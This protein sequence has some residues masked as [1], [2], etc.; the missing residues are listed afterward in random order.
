MWLPRVV[1]FDQCAPR[2]ESLI[3]P[4]H[5]MR[6]LQCSSTAHSSIFSFYYDEMDMHQTKTSILYINTYRFRPYLVCGLTRVPVS[7]RPTRQQIRLIDNLDSGRVDY[8]PDIPRLSTN[9]KAGVGGV[10]AESGRFIRYCDPYDNDMI[11]AQHKHHESTNC[12]LVFQA[13]HNNISAL[14][15][16][17]MFCRCGI[18]S[19]LHS[20]NTN[21]H[22]TIAQT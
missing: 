9:E 8:I 4:N 15:F 22:K 18:I 5:R 14:A 17:C 13:V 7:S 21:H 11:K 19:Q 12:R 2:G 6:Y 16:Y 1:G 10:A 3:K 20:K